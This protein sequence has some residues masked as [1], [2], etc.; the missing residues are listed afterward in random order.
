[1]KDLAPEI[2]RQ[3]LVIEAKPTIEITKEKIDEYLKKLSK[4]LNMALVFGP[5]TRKN[6][7]YGYSSYV[8]WEESGTHLYHWYKPFPFLTIDIYTCKKFSNEEAAKFTEDFFGAKEI[9]W[10][11]V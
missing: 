2:Y 8:Y 3:R 6:E 9:V 11:E 1:M 4:I 10:K 5:L 7:E